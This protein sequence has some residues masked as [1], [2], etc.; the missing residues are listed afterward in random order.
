[1]N[2][3]VM[4]KLSWQ[5]RLVLFASLSVQIALN[6]AGVFGENEYFRYTI[7]QIAHDQLDPIEPEDSAFG[8]WLIIYALWV[9]LTALLVTSSDSFN[10]EF[11]GR[12]TTSMIAVNGLESGWLLTFGHGHF[13]GATVMLLIA[14][15]VLYN[16]YVDVFQSTEGDTTWE[17][18]MT[19]STISVHFSWVIV[20]T[21]IQVSL[22][23][24]LHFVVA[25][26]LLGVC[27]FGL[28]VLA[29]GRRDLV[30]GAVVMWTTWNELHRDIED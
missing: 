13:E 5:H 26:T 11:A 15:A 16:L 12:L 30:V 3:A 19:R 20:A 14:S 8:I 18:W 17:A 27:L 6:V 23:L 1:M 28:L 22:H 10:S 29:W 24:Q 2:I 9:W 21:C 7:T 25:F 4:D